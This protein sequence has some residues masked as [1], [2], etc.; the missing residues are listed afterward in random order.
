MDN[1]TI[2]IPNRQTYDKI[3]HQLI[4]RLKLTF[5]Q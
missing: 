4:D 5:Y 2:H 1:T 3:Y